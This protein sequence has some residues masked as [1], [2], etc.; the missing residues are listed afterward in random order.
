MGSSTTVKILYNKIKDCVSTEVR[1]SYPGEEINS[2]SKAR[3]LT[4]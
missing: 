3:K 2:D 1:K 4:E